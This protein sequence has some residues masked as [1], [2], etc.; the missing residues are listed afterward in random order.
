VRGALTL[1]RTRMRSDV[2]DGRPFATFQSHSRSA[3]RSGYPRKRRSAL[4]DNAPAVHEWLS[5]D[6][7]KPDRFNAGPVSS[8]A[9]ARRRLERHGNRRP[10]LREARI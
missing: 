4:D 1:P 7:F 9:H 6:A 3:V 2:S 8:I 10:S 5:L